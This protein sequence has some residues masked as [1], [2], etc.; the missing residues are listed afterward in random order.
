MRCEAAPYIQHPET[1]GKSTKHP[2]SCPFETKCG[3]LNEDFVGR[4]WNSARWSCL[5]V[6]SVKNERFGEDVSF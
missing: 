1:P 6:K 3:I 2:K 4:G 5:G